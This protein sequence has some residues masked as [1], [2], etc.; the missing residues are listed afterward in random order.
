MSR[1]QVWNVLV[2]WATTN[3]LIWC[4]YP[5]QHNGFCIKIQEFNKLCKGIVP[6]LKK[7]I[8]LKIPFFVWGKLIGWRIRKLKWSDCFK[9]SMI[10]E[11]VKGIYSFQFLLSPGIW[12]ILLFWC[13]YCVYDTWFKHK[14]NQIKKGGKK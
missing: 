10:C 8:K 14:K 3:L 12:N 1:W 5:L 6:I 9:S 13:F 7:N 2:P 4:S 11:K